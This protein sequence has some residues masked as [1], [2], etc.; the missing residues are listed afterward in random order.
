M[1]SSNG[2]LFITLSDKTLKAGTYQ[3]AVNLYLRGAQ[4][5][6]GSSYGTPIP[7]VIDVVVKE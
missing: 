6:E 7:M 2:Y 3:V 4:P 1:Q 5:V